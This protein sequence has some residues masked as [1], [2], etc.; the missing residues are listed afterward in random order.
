MP[1]PALIVLAFEARDM[2]FKYGLP[3]LEYRCDMH[4]GAVRFFIYEAPKT[5]RRAAFLL[6][7][8]L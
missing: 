1:S 8:P 7:C 4:E 5:T 2:H 3:S 6:L